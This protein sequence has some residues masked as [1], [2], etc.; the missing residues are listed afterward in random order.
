MS[1]LSTTLVLFF[2]M[3]PIGNVNSFLTMMRHQSPRRRAFVVLREMFFALILMLLFNFM[4]E[5]LQAVLELS[6]VS[7]HLATGVVLLLA[8]LGILFPGPRSVRGSLPEEE[9]FLV[10]LAIP[11][12]SGPALLATIMLYSQQE[13]SVLLMLVAIFVAWLAAVI[14]LLLAPVL[15]RLMGKNGLIAAERLCAMVLVMLAI[16]R[17]FEGVRLF[18]TSGT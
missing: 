11:L 8:A 12:I 14:V 6:E 3:D 5:H 1:L 2:I 13:E 7:V 10:P 9:P 16:Q 4:G 15:N 17:F 18:V